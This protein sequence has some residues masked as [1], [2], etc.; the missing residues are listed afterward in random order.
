M[1]NANNFCNYA[2]TIE[3]W[4]AVFKSKDLKRGTSRALNIAKQQ[5]L[6]RRN[7]DGSVIAV[8]RYCPHMGTDL[9]LAKETQSKLQC[10]FHGLEFNPNGECVQTCAK[11]SNFN[12]RTYITAEKFGFIFVYIGEGP[13][14][15]EL[16]DLNLDNGMTIYSPTQKIN[17]HPHM[18]LCNG[19]DSVHTK[20]VHSW[21]SFDYD[22]TMHDTNV[23]AKLRGE[24]KAWWMRF[25]NFTYKKP[26]EFTFTTYGSSIAIADVQW[27]RTRLVILFTAYLD[28]TVSYTNTGLY[29]SSYNPIRWIRGAIVTFSILWQDAKI[30]NS[31]NIKQNFT[32]EDAGVIMYRDVLN[33]MSLYSVR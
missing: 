3:D 7:K 16:P 5:L 33:S 4:Y 9:L 21:D 28:G 29:L 8:Q 15:R 22:V 18:V 23:I 17:C 10:P 11:T 14:K 31:M 32:K 25:L 12:L 20:F 30:M 2:V 24:Y 19:L 6:V 1:E 13:P 26:L 27:N